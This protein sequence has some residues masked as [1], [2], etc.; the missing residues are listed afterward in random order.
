MKCVFAKHTHILI[1]RDRVSLYNN[2][3]YSGTHFIDQTGV[4]L[5]DLHA[6]TFRLKGLM[7]CATTPNQRLFLRIAKGKKSKGTS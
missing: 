5:T 7:V 4:K 6:S 2:P 3:S 1:F